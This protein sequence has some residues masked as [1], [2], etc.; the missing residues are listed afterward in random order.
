MNDVAAPAAS[1]RTVSFTF[2]D[3]VPVLESGGILDYVHCWQNSRYYEPPV[4]LDGLSRATRANVYLGPA[5]ASIPAGPHLQAQ[6]NAEP[7]GL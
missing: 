2:G 6:Q 3:P 1:A 4:S 5:C 7:L